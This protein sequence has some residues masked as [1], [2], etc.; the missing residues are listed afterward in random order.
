MLSRRAWRGWTLG[1]IVG[2]AAYVI[3]AYMASGA[4]IPGVLIGIW[5]PALGIYQW[6][7]LR[8]HESA[9]AADRLL[10][11]LLAAQIGYLLVADLPG[12]PL[13]DDCVER[14]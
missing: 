1:C 7:Q 2:V 6:S 14:E 5:F 11:V 4:W 8:E 9:D 10:N 3:Y 12:E 13:R